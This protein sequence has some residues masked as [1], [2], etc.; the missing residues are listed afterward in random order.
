MGKIKISVIGAGSWGTT[1]AILLAEKK[2]DVVL[3]ARRK[4]L[5]DEI[6]RAR[7]NKQYLGDIKLPDSIAVTNS[8]EVISGSKVIV[9]AVPSEFLRSTAK[10]FSKFIESDSLVVHVIKGIEE[11]TGKL[12]SEVLDEELSK[13]IKIAALSGP[14]HAEEVSRNLPTATVI[15]SRNSDAAKFLCRIFET[16]YFK[17][18]PHDDI[19]GVEICSVIKNII[20]IAIGVCDGLN[21]GDNAKASIVTLGLSEMSHVSSKFGG[22]RATSFGLAGVGDLIATCYSPHSRNRFVG[23][24]LAEGKSIN[25]VKKEMKGMVAEGIKNTKSVYELCK[26]KGI[27]TPLITQAYSVLYRNTDLKQAIAQLLDK[28]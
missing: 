19:T 4:E 15:A 12:M 6:S 20:A 10:V 28:V 1:L 14:N 17:V 8:A 21:F 18:Y 9:F 2:H 5:A 7:K 16:P 27:E 22:K 26:K 13:G 24:M 25:E 23:Q 11:S 3:W